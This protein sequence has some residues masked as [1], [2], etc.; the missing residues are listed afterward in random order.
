MMHRLKTIPDQRGFTLVEISI[1]MVIIALLVGS[2]LA[3]TNL[4]HNARLKSVMDDKK[5]YEEAIETFRD[6][7]K[8]LPGDFASATTLW[9]AADVADC[10]LGAHSA[11]TCAQLATPS[12]NACTCDGDGNDSIYGNSGGGYTLHE[13]FRVWQH[14]ANAQLITGRFSGVNACSTNSFG[15][16]TPGLNAPSS[17]IRNAAWAIYDIAP[18]GGTNAMFFTSYSYKHVLLFAGQ[19]AMTKPFNAI[20]SPK[21]AWSLDVKFDDGLPGKGTMLGVVPFSGTGIIDNACA[22]SSNAETAAYTLSDNDP[23]CI[24]IFRQNY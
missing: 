15:C 5:R 22:T 8:A 17:E 11:T 19:N 2:I 6:R 14:L 7:Y 20:L 9:G 3:G 18:D 13:R 16:N 12:T 23:E 1:V 24:L 4:L 21:D 10:S